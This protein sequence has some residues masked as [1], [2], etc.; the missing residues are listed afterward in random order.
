MATYW[1]EWLTPGQR[2]SGENREGERICIQWLDSQA[3]I[4]WRL[5]GLC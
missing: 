1:L 3:T 5:P 4:T 2:Q